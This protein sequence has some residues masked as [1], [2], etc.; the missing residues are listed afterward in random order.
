MSETTEPI[1][2]LR[3]PM[4]YYCDLPFDH[5]FDSMVDENTQR[6]FIGYQPCEKCAKPISEGFLIMGVVQEP[7]FPDQPPIKE[8]DGIK[9]YPTQ[10]MIVLSNVARDALRQ[11]DPNMAH[12]KDDTPGIYMPDAYVKDLIDLFNDELIKQQNKTNGVADNV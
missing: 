4:C 7:T 12:V 5:A 6:L 11:N 8:Q 3:L 9:L 1:K 2:P 10:N